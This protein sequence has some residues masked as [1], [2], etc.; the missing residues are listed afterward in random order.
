MI[1]I[2]VIDGSDAVCRTLKRGLERRGGCW[3]FT[4][5]DWRS[6]ARLARKIRPH[7]VILDVDL[8]DREAFR[9]IDRLQ[10]RARTRYVPVLAMSTTD[11][12]HT[13]RRAAR[14]YVEH[15]LVK[16]FDLRVLRAQLERVLAL[17]GIRFEF[18]PEPAVSLRAA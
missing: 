16:P 11:D 4:S 8:P 1:R 5:T 10:A 7:C 13:R 9:L 3:V 14:A 2:L 15:Y 6:G 18:D 12:P 17:R